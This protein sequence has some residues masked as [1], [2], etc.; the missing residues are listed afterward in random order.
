[1]FY[2]GENRVREVKT[3]AQGHTAGHCP[4]FSWDPGLPDSEAV[5]GTRL[6]RWWRS[7]GRDR[8][9]VLRLVSE[10]EGRAVEWMRPEEAG[11]SGSSGSP[12]Q[13][14]CSGWPLCA[15]QEGCLSDT[16]PVLGG[17]R[18]GEYSPWGS[19]RRRPVWCWLPEIGEGLGVQERSTI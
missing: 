15:C 11:L 16:E 18:Q 17:R 7:F 2:R 9:E 3:L 4:H 12:A 6:Q 10:A 5:L 8:D 13:Q 19:C 14:L 1:M